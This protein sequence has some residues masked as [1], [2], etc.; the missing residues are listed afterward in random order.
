MLSLSTCVQVVS[1]VY[2]TVCVCFKAKNVV[3]FKIAA[4]HHC[5]IK[6]VVAKPAKYQDV[7]LAI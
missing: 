4:A 3:Y 5:A 1:S 6:V 7:K 2:Q